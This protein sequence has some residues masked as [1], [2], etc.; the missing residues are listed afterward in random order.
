ME[1]NWLKSKNQSSR[2]SARGRQRQTMNAIKARSVHPALT[3]MT[4][5]ADTHSLII[6]WSSRPI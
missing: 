6:S 5:P 1:D 2:G 4:W 3:D